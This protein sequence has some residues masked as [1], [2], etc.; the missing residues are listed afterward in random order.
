MSPVAKQMMLNTAVAEHVI[1]QITL[2][3]IS[4]Q[5]QLACN[6]SVALFSHLP[7]LSAFS[8][9]DI[10]LSV[11][12]TKRK[13]VS[14]LAEL[15]EMSC[16]CSSNE[17]TTTQVRHFSSFVGSSSVVQPLMLFVHPRVYCSLN[18]QVPGSSAAHHYQSC[19]CFI[20]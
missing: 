8:N 13:P 2:I 16:L 6:K 17:C 7:N 14:W 11:C 18:V 19:T 3:G 20:N 15:G 9:D 1:K 12:A 10:C 4:V 5:I